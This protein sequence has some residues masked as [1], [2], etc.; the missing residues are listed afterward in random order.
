MGVYNDEE[1]A[2]SN[3]TNDLADAKPAE[4]FVLQVFGRLN[5]DCWY[6]A[7]EGYEPRGDMLCTHCNTWVEVKYDHLYGKTG[8]VFVEVDTL[9]HTQAKY[10]VVVVEKW[11]R[12]GDNWKPTGEI[13]PF[14]YVMDM[15]KLKEACRELWRKGKKPV[16]GGEFK[17]MQGY[18]LPLKTLQKA[19]WVVTVMTKVTEKYASKK[20][21]AELFKQKYNRVHGEQRDYRQRNSYR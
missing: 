1:K 18:P 17:K 15:E 6:T 11:A 3:F 10:F 7:S 16:A 13:D 2:A 14:I 20:P 9:K 19:D 12:V 5:K 4:D 8:N 21:I